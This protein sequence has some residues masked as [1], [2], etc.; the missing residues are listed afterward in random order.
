[1]THQASSTDQSQASEPN[2]EFLSPKKLFLIDGLGATLS[3]FLLAIALVK[4]EN[5]FG[6][7]RTTL[8]FLAHF[9]C[10][11]ALYD[12]Y[13]FQKTPQNVRFFLSCIAYANLFYCCL[14]IGFALYH[15]QQLTYLGIIYI[16]LEVVIIIVLAGFE[17]KIAARYK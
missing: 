12:F 16:L 15:F 8:Y 7:P 6:L 13:C 14:S 17:L 4:F 2:K 5:I 11:F 9:P 10:I 3:F 1:M